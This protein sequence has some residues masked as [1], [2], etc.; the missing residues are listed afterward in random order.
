MSPIRRQLQPREKVILA[1]TVLVIV[2]VG[3][4]FGVL[5]GY[6]ERYQDV[7]DRLDR[8]RRELRDQSKVLEQA[9][10]TDTAYQGLD[11]AVSRPS[12]GKRPDRAFTEDMEKLFKSLKLPKPDLGTVASNEIPDVAGFSFVVL[13]V[14]NVSGNL[15]TITE[16]LKE[17][18]ERDLII[19]S[20]KIENLSRRG[21][22]MT[23]SLAKVIRTEDLQ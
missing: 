14:R 23:V 20:L 1:V 16:L 3:A 5:E 9:E 11:R 12:E 10:E 4:W 21:L 7:N 18:A 17:F 15:G 6:I 2:G 22:M 19:L 13:P 8:A